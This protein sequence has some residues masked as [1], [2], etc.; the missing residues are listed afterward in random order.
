MKKRILFFLACLFLSGLW[1]WCTLAI[2]FSGLPETLAFI[3]CGIFAAGVPLAFIFLPNRKRTTYGVFILCIFVLTGWSQVEPSHDRDWVPSVGKLPYATIEGNQFRIHNIRNFDYRTEKDFSVRYYDKI[4]NLNKLETVDYV[5]SHW[6]ENEAVAHSIFSF[7]FADG[8]Y[9]AVSVETRLEEGELQSG[10]RGLFKQYE[11]IY[12][13][14]DERDLLRLRTNFRKEDV[15]LY[16]TTMGKKNIR[17]IFNVIMERVNNI[18]SRPEFYNTLTQS[19]LSSL[20]GDFKRVIAPKSLF[21]IRRLANGYSDEMLYENGWI[22][23]KLSFA[24]TKRLHYINQYVQDDIDSSDY[25]RKIRPHINKEY[26][27]VF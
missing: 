25:S 19:C 12:V 7:G 6:D 22:D 8:D 14:G 27:W 20:V 18:A 21:D 9:L 10:L 24:E 11:L 3:A 5:L 16:P 2:L 26:S 23:S 1:L 15:F 17:K 4:F 13:L